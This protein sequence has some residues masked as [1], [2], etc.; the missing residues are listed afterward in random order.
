MNLAL[1]KTESE[2]ERN[3]KRFLSIEALVLRR[4]RIF[5]NIT[6]EEAGKAIDRSAKVFE[7]YEN[8]RSNLSI[9][10]RKALVRRYR[11]TWEE[12]LRFLAN[13]DDLP[14]LPATHIHKKTQ[15][16]RTEGRKYKKLIT[17]EARILKIIRK[18]QGF[19]QPEAAAKC[20]WSRS[21]IDH[22]ENGR[23]EIDD[24]KIQHILKSYG[25]K[26]DLYLELFE[27]PFLRDEVLNECLQILTKLDNDKLRAVKALLDN[28]R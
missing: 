28:F 4:M 6:R 7:R 12:Y 26:R 13:P 15:V 2:P 3:C 23:V 20:G 17:K 10:Q 22:L 11:Y 14:D 25:C 19:T 16:P 24:S 21:C 5:R 27:A 8:A 18:M 9:N 1:V